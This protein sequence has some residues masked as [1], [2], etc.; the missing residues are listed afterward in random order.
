MAKEKNLQN[1][2]FI[3]D[4]YYKRTFFQTGNYYYNQWTLK[5][6]QNVYESVDSKGVESLDKDLTIKLIYVNNVWPSYTRDSYKLHKY[7]DFGF[8]VLKP[9]D[10]KWSSNR[11]FLI[12]LFLYTNINN[13][14]ISII[15][16]LCYTHYD[17]N[18]VE[19]IILPQT[20]RNKRR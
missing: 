18:L 6:I 10:F 11:L 5:E 20:K 4:N 7:S 2:L 13:L 3:T 16:F 1:V 8:L 17:Y 12:T 19:P 14:D 9:Q 15:S